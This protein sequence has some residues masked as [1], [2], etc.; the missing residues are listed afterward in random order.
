MTSKWEGKRNKHFFASKRNCSCICYSFEPLLMT[1]ES[2][3]ELFSF[4]IFH[5]FKTTIFGHNVRFTHYTTHF[6]I[7]KT[8]TIFKSAKSCIKNNWIDKITSC[9]KEVN[10]WNTMHMRVHMMYLCDMMHTNAY[11]WNEHFFLK[12]E[13]HRVD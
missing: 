1:H 2:Q 9:V 3:I 5:I 8:I 11:G 6:L 7:S 13:I 12:T 4:K 10:K